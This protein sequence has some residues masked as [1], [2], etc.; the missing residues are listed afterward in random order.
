[1]LATVVADLMFATWADFVKL[2]PK[3]YILWNTFIDINH[4]IIDFFKTFFR[5]TVIIFWVSKLF[6]EALDL[7]HMY[8]W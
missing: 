6:S 3:W 5:V 1:M 2:C 4:N 7:G 8:I